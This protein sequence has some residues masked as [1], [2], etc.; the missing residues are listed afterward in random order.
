[1]VKTSRTRAFP[2]AL[3]SSDYSPPCT[4]T[5]ANTLPQTALLHPLLGT[6]GQ[7]VGW[8]HPEPDT[9]MAQPRPDTLP[10]PLVDVLVP[11]Q[12][13]TPNSCGEN[14]FRAASVPKEQQAYPK[15]CPLL[16]GTLAKD[17]PPVWG[18]AR[19][20]QC[21]TQNSPCMEEFL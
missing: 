3:C 20:L 8:S 9:G 17:A 6:K 5:F 12:L 18:K 21:G 16:L 19:L 14:S 1:M 10:F 7:S 4:H 13:L 2:F 11:W 15:G